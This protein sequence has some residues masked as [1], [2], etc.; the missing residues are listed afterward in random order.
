M[1]VLQMGN[2]NQLLFSDSRRGEHVVLVYE[3]GPGAVEQKLPEVVFIC[4]GLF[5]T[6]LYHCFLFY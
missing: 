2:P 1:C 6:A 3:C 5:K 4:E